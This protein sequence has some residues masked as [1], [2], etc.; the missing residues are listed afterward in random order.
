M[1]DIKFVTD[2]ELEA[3]FSDDSLKLYMR[4]IKRYPILDGHEIV[5]LYKQ[6]MEDDF[7]MDKLDI[8]FDTLKTVKETMMQYTVSMNQKV[9]D[10]ESMI[11]SL[12]DLV[13]VIN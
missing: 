12:E 7:V 9:G 10:E 3:S 1:E 2:A 4:E 11:L 13:I 6:Y 5:R 8:G